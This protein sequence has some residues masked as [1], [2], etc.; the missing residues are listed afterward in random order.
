M[1]RR[2]FLTSLLK[3]AVAVPLIGTGTSVFLDSTKV[4]TTFDISWMEYGERM[5]IL[6]G[7]DDSFYHALAGGG[8]TIVLSRDMRIPLKLRPGGL[9]DR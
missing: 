5:T 1:D 2:F 8:K 4:F 3:T 6:F 9:F 7:R